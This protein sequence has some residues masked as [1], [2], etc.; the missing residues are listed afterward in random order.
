MHLYNYFKHISYKSFWHLLVTLIDVVN[1][2]EAVHLPW[3]RTVKKET[4]IK[5]EEYEKTRQITGKHENVC[6]NIIRIV[7]RISSMELTKLKLRTLLL[8]CTH[9]KA[10]RGD[11]RNVFSWSYVFV[12]CAKVRYFNHNCKDHCLFPLRRPSD[13]YPSI[14]GS[15]AVATDILRDLVKGS[16]VGNTFSLGLV[17]YIFVV[18]SYFS[19]HL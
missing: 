9:F 4:K 5:Y 14:Y 2:C 16:W 1:R 10:T 19:I 6:E 13:T 17:G 15:I 8:T 12:K 18:H 7:I 11:S 3:P